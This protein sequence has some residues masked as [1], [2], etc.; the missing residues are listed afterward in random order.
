MRIR[1][2]GFATPDTL[3]T[4]DADAAK[5]FWAEHGTVIYKSI[6][7]VRSIVARLGETHLPRMDD[8]AWCPTQ[9]QQY[10]PGDDYRVHVVGEEVFACRIRC[11]A[12]DYRYASRQDLPVSIEACELPSEC[13]ERCRRLASS[14]DLALAGVDLRLTPDGR[15]FCFEVNPSPA[16]SYYQNTTGQPIA[17][18]VAHLLMQGNAVPAPR[19]R[20]LRAV[21]H[22]PGASTRWTRRRS[23]GG[24]L[25]SHE[26]EHAP[27]PQHTPATAS[28]QDGE[29]SI[30]GIAADRANA[31]TCVPLRRKLSQLSASA[32]HVER[33]A[34]SRR[35]DRRTPGA[36]F[37]GPAAG[38]AGARADGDPLRLR[39]QPC[40]DPRRRGGGKVGTICQRPRLHRR[41]PCCVRRWPLRSIDA[42]GR[43]LAGARIGTRCAAGCD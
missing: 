4:T 40:A 18:A 21:A 24:T 28:R 13:A 37:T 3:I 35:A 30:A 32:R 11:A 31:S 36:V 41:Q 26:L 12:D 7:G 20:A 38:P 2:F 42:R 10:V 5:A 39:L 17:A 25:G 34:S 9:F 23:A 15:W 33:C 27:G 43:S 16:F 29:S 19:P 22:V 14:M 6:S 1:S 8:L